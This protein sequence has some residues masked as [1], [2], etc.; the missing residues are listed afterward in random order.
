MVSFVLKTSIKSIINVDNDVII[1]LKLKGILLLIYIN[2]Y[3]Y[4]IYYFTFSSIT[5]INNKSL[6]LKKN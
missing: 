2:R 4:F 6:F 1:Q 5:H 3:P